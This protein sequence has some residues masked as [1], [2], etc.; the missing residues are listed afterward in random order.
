MKILLILGVTVLVAVALYVNRQPDEVAI[1]SRSES[2][3]TP[4]Q[5]AE[6]PVAS[7]ENET[8]KETTTLVASGFRFSISK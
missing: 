3:M 1:T 6:T 2:Q 4:T 7:A 5:H 8:K